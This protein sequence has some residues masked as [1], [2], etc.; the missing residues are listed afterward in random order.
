MMSPL[1]VAQY[2]KADSIEFDTVVFDEAS[3]I[4]PQDAVSSLI[5]ADQAVIAGDTKQLPPTS[6]F[7]SD[8]ETTEDVREDLDS[9][10]EETASVLPERSLRWHYR[11]RTEELIQFSNYHYYDNSLR[12]FPENDPDTETGVSFE[13]VEDG[14]YDRGGSRQNEIEARRV[15]DLIEEHAEERSDKSL[16]VV[17]FSS[18]QERAI[19]DALAERREENPVLDA[20]VGRDDVLDEFFVKN[21]EMVQGD[22]RD[23]MIFSVGYGPARDGRI[24]T[25]FGPLNKS[26]GERRLNVAVTRAKE[27]IT[28]VCSMLP[29]DIDLS[30]SNSIGAEHFKNYL[31]YARKGERALGRNDRVTDTLDF[32]SQFEETVYDALK[33]EGY[34][35]VSQVRSSSYS[36][37]L[38]IKHPNRPGKFILGIECDGAAYHSSK[39]ARDRDRTRQSVLENLGWTIHRIWSPDWASNR[40]KQIQEIKKTVDSIMSGDSTSRGRVDVPAHEPEAVA[41]KSKLDHEALTEFVEPSLAWNDRYSADKRGQSTAN[42]NSIRDT[43]RRN[44]PIEYETAI[45]TYLDVWAQSRVGKRVR[46]AF[47]SGVST[48]EKRNE[49]YQRGDFLWPERS[50]LD[51]KVRVNTESA[52]RSIDE[53]PKEEIAKGVAVLLEEGGSM[54]RD[55]LI[56]ETT[57]LIGYQRRGKRIEERLG[58]AID[59]LEDAGAVE[60]D[61]DEKIHLQPDARINE[62]LLS[63]IY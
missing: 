21:L 6:F 48:L 27:Q 8:V 25:N 62:A 44:G 5:R 54:T 20:F 41:G 46:R 60:Y 56:L 24:S 31:E 30:G 59:I 12:T 13:H 36:I 9:I 18:A 2:L 52:T 57:R 42:R 39:T 38:A 55:D 28:V 49:I 58:E 63:R 22:E 4:M 16:G 23:R 11:S 50:D 34:D 47:E 26:G 19:R 15:I 40:E 43:I 10:L 37:D 32:D 61:E 53:I 7:Q 29:G 45:R 35:V 51:F 17:A 1:S 33:A 3:Q 14:V